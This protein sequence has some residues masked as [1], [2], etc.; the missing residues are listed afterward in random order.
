MSQ[1]TF[2]YL[3]K[4]LVVTLSLLTGLIAFT[5]FS[6]GYDFAEN[7]YNHFI[8]QSDYISATASAFFGYGLIVAA[9]FVID[10]FVSALPLV[11]RLTNFL[12]SYFDIKVV[13]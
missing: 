8:D 13:Q 7:H 2:S 10:F 5:L 12:H 11:N 9:I 4:L 3:Q 6:V 1:T